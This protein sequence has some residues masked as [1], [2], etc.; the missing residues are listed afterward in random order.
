M[1]D[2]GNRHLRSV[3]SRDWRSCL[4]T[5]IEMLPWFHA[6]NRSSYKRRKALYRLHMLRLNETY[7]DA[8]SV[9]MNGSLTSIQLSRNNPSGLVTINQGTDMLVNR[10]QESHGGI[11]N[12]STQSDAVYKC[13]LLSPQRATF[14]HKCKALAFGEAGA[15][16]NFHADDAGRKQRKRDE[17]SVQR[18]METLRMTINP[19]EIGRPTTNHFFRE[20]CS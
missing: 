12:V 11:T 5:E 3:R 9:L 18:I 6:A 1:V 4:E 7:T 10:D 15:S 20:T 17:A 2:L 13:E 16:N 19:F 8:N 14:V